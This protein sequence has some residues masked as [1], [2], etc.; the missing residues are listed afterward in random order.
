M[1]LE[2]DVEQLLADAQRHRFCLVHRSDA[3]II[4]RRIRHRIAVVLSGER[5]DTA[6]AA[7]ARS[8]ASRSTTRSSAATSA[9]ATSPGASAAPAAAVGRAEQA[10]QRL[11]DAAESAAGRG[12]VV[13]ARHEP[14]HAVVA[15]VVGLRR[16]DRNQP[17]IAL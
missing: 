10:A 8:A 17:S 13:I 15:L 7:S 2:R 6:Q 4:R 14:P 1:K 16:A 11:D 9:A 5:S 12:D 3:G